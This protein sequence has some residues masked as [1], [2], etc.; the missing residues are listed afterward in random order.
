M[1]CVIV[2]NGEFCKHQK[3]I[4]T[5]KNAD[6]IIACDGAAN[7]LIL[8]HYKVDIIIGDLDSFN[9]TTTNAKIIKINNQNTNDLTKAFKYALNQGFNDIII[10]GAGGKRDDHF[11][12]NLS[13]FTQYFKLKNKYKEKIKI[14][15][16]TNYGEF[17]IFNNDFSINTYIGQQ[18]SL[19]CFDDNARFSSDKLKYNLKKFKFKYL[20]SGT[21]NEALSS[22][23]SIINHDKKEIIVYLSY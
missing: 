10:L 22:N 14:S 11:I 16:Q 21:L 19:F 5:L 18:I 12:A 2:A 6:F 4:N 13:L 15:M 17:F 20:N 7:N 8:N 23:F 3:P 9:K 1:K